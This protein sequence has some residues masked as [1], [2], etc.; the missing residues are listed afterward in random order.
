MLFKNNNMNIM[1]NR[2]PYMH[3]K[4]HFSSNFT[5]NW[6]HIIINFMDFLQM[7][8]K[9]RPVLSHESVWMITSGFSEILFMR[10]ERI[11]NVDLEKRLTRFRNFHNKDSRKIWNFH[12]VTMD[13]YFSWQCSNDRG[14]RQGTQFPL[15]HTIWQLTFLGMSE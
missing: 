15:M 8:R 5:K 3:C 1:I 10:L 7:H 13:S 11:K 2:C 4:K 12:C 14:F 9:I 6:H